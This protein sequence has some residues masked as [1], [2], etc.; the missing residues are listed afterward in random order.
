[1]MIKEVEDSKNSVLNHFPN[2]KRV[3]LS[4]ET[5]GVTVPMKSHSQIHLLL[6]VILRKTNQSG[7][8]THPVLGETSRF[9]VI[10]REVCRN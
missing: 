8:T 1:M 10:P 7:S 6:K 2:S 5:E 4:G 9:I 3:Y